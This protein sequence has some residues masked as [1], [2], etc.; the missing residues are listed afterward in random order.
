MAA[1]CQGLFLARPY[2]NKILITSS[3]LSY[4]ILPWGKETQLSI[5]TDSHSSSSW[6]L[7]QDY[8][9]LNPNNHFLLSKE[10]IT[11][12]YANHLVRNEQTNQQN[13]FILLLAQEK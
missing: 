9:G 4:I 7:F 2:L 12:L 3:P 13:Q 1:I 6:F 8:L 5:A 11:M 10:K